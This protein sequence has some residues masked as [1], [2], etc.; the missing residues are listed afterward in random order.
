[1]LPLLDKNREP[2][3]VLSQAEGFAN[4]PKDF[5]W[6]GKNIP[7]QKAC[8][9]GTDIP[10]YLHA[11]SQGNFEQAYFINL[12]DNVFP[13]VLGRVCSRPCEPAC[14][15]GWEGLGDPVAIC[16]SKRSSADFMHKNPVVL[17]KIF[18]PTDRKVA[19]IG[20]GVA[21]LAAARDLALFGHDVVVY[22]KHSSPGGML[23][24]GIP[25]FRLPRSIIEKEVHQVELCGV[26]IVCDT[27]IGETV[28]LQEL[29]MKNDAVIMAAGTLKPNMLHIQGNH[30]SGITHGL[31]YLLQV[32]EFNNNRIGQNVL[33]IGGGFT[34]MDCARTSLRSGA[35][36]VK[37]YYRRSRNEMLVTDEE[38]RE[39]EVEGIPIHYQVAPIRYHGDSSGRFTAIEF[40]KTELGKNDES[41]RCK[42][43]EISGSEFQV[44]ADMVQLATGQFPET[45][46]IDQSLKTDLVD[47]N[48]W[49]ISGHSTSTA[50]DKIFV[51]GDF[52][53][54][55]TT[56]ID[57]I[58]HARRC[59]R[60]VD[61]FLC[62]K[63]RL[64]DV[65]SVENIDNNSRNPKH[66]SISLHVMP[67]IPPGERT[68]TAEVE[69][70][71]LKADAKKEAL[72]CYLCHFKYEIDNELCIYCDGCLRVMPVEN[73]IVKVNS[74]T[75]DDDGQITGYIRSQNS[76]DY[77][78]LYID[79]NEC[80]RC[81]ACADVCPV[82][83]IPI[84]KVSKKN[85][86]EDQLCK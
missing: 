17:P 19:V 83:C 61:R 63:D 72:R 34:A 59:A 73:C 7:C 52:A 15:H 21:G 74:L 53:L 56:L 20:A 84:Q 25:E 48:G 49:L 76:Y 36:S 1:M 35:E 85:V 45:E 26:K 40:V 60:D 37:V 77:N 6:L 3:W 78:M 29:V 43:T 64:F 14:R 16:F 46:W 47:K 11:V 50:V 22:E 27:H 65:V 24:Q 9:A 23:N 69:T 13:A 58:G 57:A 2:H 82:E 31:D 10:E 71:Y 75:Y 68:L 79:Q 67:M 33:V 70:G 30:F 62:G 86:T 66:N 54:G 8:P 81:G 12:R 39:L 18:G 5:D 80:I 55:A 41:G 51:A 4:Q 28:S 38:I 44:S 42:P 32:N